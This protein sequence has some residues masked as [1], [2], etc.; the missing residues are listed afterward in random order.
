M[1]IALYGR[2][3]TKD[4][5]QDSENQLKQLRDYA[6]RANLEIVE[7]Y[8]DQ[9]SGSGKAVRERF[10]AMMQDAR[11]RKFDLL[12]FWSLDRLSREGVL[13][14]LT[15]LKNLNN[16]GVNWKSYTEQYLD[17]TGL[18]KDAII[19]IIAAIAKQERVRISERVKAGLD[20]AREQGA[21]VGR[22]KKIFRRDLAIE[23][24]QAGKSI[25]EIARELD[26]S[27]AIAHRELVG[28]PKPLPFPIPFHADSIDSSS[29]L[30]FV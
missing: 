2:V 12:L 21:I 7:E 5:G 30:E 25:R 16:W 13:E 22:P 29:N 26:V 28:V 15:Y 3:S 18:F 9:A 14:T 6:S 19:A 10:E 27:P 17:S 11:Q 24:R 1:K 8:A 4:K 23:M 20:R